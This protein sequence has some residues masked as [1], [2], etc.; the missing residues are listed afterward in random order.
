MFKRCFLVRNPIDFNKEVRGNQLEL[1]SE[2]NMFMEKMYDT[3]DGSETLLS[4]VDVGSCAHYLQGFSTIPGGS[5]DFWT[6]NSM[7]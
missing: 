2:W 1:T 3:V 5:P 6:I 4:P 7:A